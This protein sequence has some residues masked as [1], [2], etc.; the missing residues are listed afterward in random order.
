[1]PSVTPNMVNWSAVIRPYQKRH[2][3]VVKAS[4]MFQP[5][6]KAPKP[7]WTFQIQPM[8]VARGA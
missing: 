1:M 6:T 3:G 2:A 8:A 4:T 5:R 7:A